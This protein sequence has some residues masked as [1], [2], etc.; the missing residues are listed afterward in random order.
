[1]KKRT[2]KKKKI[3]KECWCLDFNFLEW[4][5]IRLPIYLKEAGSTVD[6][7]YHKFEY[8]GKTMTQEEI[9]KRMIQLLKEIEGKD[10]WDPH[11]EYKDKV[12][13]ILDIWKLVFH[14]MWW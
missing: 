2:I 12:D 13:E 9:I 14:A 4:L 10:C 6:L 11:E 8:K 3:S 5:R 1:M 7:T